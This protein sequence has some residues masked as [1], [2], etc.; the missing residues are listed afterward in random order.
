MIKLTKL[1]GGTFHINAIFIEKIES[2]PDTTITLTNGHKYIVVE[3]EEIVSEKI[4]SFYQQI[5]LLGD[6]RLGQ[7]QSE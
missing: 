2:F 6:N 3:T 1:N 4:I 5:N 7:T